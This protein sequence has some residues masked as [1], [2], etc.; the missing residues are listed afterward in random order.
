MLFAATDIILIVNRQKGRKS[1]FFVTSAVF[2]TALI[3]MGLLETF[4]L[5]MLIFGI[6]LVI[7]SYRTLFEGDE[8]NKTCRRS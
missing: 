2:L 3:I 1:V 8:E 6:V 5:Y 7:A 4:T